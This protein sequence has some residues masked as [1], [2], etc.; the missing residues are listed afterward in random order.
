[1]QLPRIVITGASG[2]V[3][4]HLLDALKGNYKIFALAR[5]SQRRCGAPVHPNILWHRVDIGDIE[6]LEVIFQKIA[7]GGGADIFIHLAAYYDFSG[8]EHPEY[9]RTNVDGLRNILNLCKQLRLKKFIFA[10]STAACNFPRAGKVLNENSPP[11]GGHI[12]ARTKKIGEEMLREYSETIPSTIVRFAAL[13]SDWCEYPPIY[14]FLDSWLS[15]IWISRILAGKGR[16]AI[17]YLHIRDIVSFIENLMNRID[18]IE[19]GEVFIASPDGAVTHQQLFDAATLAFYGQTKKAILLPKLLC[20]IGI[21][22]RT[23]LGRITGYRPFESPWM[24]KYIDFQM[25]MDASRTRKRLGWQP[26]PRLDILRRIPFIVENFRA[27]PGEWVH[28]N[29]AALKAVPQLLHLKIHSLLKIHE[30]E[31]KVA[32]TEYI[33]GPEGREKFPNYQ[34]MPAEDR[35]WAGSQVFLHLANAIRAQD[36]SVFKAYCQELAEH[37][38]EQGFS[39]QNVCN[40]LEAWN[41]VCIR[42]LEE[43]PAS[44][45]LPKNALR[46]Y[47]TMTIQFGIDE[48]QEV[49]EQFGSDE[50]HS[51]LLDIES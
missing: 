6:P 39:L 28:R 34:D 15:N 8:E 41:E 27:E 31:I 11:N 12:Y 49:F 45:D 51:H 36:K 16:S 26:K 21:I 48:V 44:T 37:R 23:T 24:C 25:N 29:T 5:R 38:F 32:I 18:D 9:W 2:F 4:R 14:M 30:R 47:V 10:S 13:L 35:K 1:M 40:A 43:D 3:G 7:N 46:D 42:I 33:L 20:R 22:F 17:P 19:P 50:Y